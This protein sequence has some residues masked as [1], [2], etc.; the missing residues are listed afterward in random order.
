MSD[1]RAVFSDEAPLGR[2]GRLFHR[3]RTGSSARLPWRNLHLSGEQSSGVGFLLYSGLSANG[4]LA[5]KKLARELYRRFDRR[6]DFWQRNLWGH[7]GRYGDFRQSRMWNW[8]LDAWRAA[9]GLMSRRND[10]RVIVIGHSTGAL[11]TVLVGWLFQLLAQWSG[12]RSRIGGVVL[13]APAFQLRNRRNIRL[14]TMILIVYYLVSP[15]MFLLLVIDNIRL[16][17]AV[18]VTAGCFYFLLPR[19]RV[20]TGHAVRTCAPEE[21]ER[22]K[23]A[24][25][26]DRLFALGLV[27]YFGIFPLMLMLLALVLPDTPIRAMLWTFFASIMVCI[28]LLPTGRVLDCD[29]E[30]V[31]S[32]APESSGY[33]WLPVVTAATLLPLQWVSRLVVRRLQCPVLMILMERDYVVEAAMARA[34]FDEIP[35]ED[36]TLRELEG[37]P[38]ADASLEQQ[39]FLA[40][41]IEAWVRERIDAPRPAEEVAAAEAFRAGAA[42]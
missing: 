7:T 26:R 40:D 19:I 37:M 2:L 25:R 5:Q 28:W 31:D 41:V 30:N 29:W 24:G 4:A 34:L 33:C 27:I 11:V 8:L 42:V 15:L 23:L 17:D 13:K 18:L 22:M 3:I 32:E 35:S 12:S 1:R 10:S 39:V 21:L 9:R 20:P 16:W 38:H 14:L 6:V 36:K